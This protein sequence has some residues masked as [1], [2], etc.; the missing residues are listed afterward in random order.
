MWVWFALL[1]KFFSM[2]LGLILHSAAWI[3]GFIPF[4]NLGKCWFYYFF[5]YIFYL[6]LFRSSFWNSIYTNI[7][8]LDLSTTYSYCLF[9]Q[10]VFLILDRFYYS[11]FTFT[12]L[13]LYNDYS[14][15]PIDKN[16]QD[17]F[18][19]YFKEKQRILYEPKLGQLSR[20]YNLQ[21]EESALGK[22]YLVQDYIHFLH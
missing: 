11:V 16:E 20:I 22:E 7:N 4:S 17:S 14:F 12:I 8:F 5:K 2:F 10:S 18:F 3:C 1:Y 13:F 19:F 15:N 6:F 21:Q 9:F